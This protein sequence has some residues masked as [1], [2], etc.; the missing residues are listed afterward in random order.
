M[1]TVIEQ[2][3]NLFFKRQEQKANDFDSLAR[4]I[5]AGDDVEPDA[6]IEVLDDVG[7]SAADLDSKV[8]YYK[9]RLALKAKVD[10]LPELQSKKADVLRTAGEESERWVKLVEEHR[11]ILVPLGLEEEKLNA[12]IQ[13]A[14]AAGR[15]LRTSYVGPAI[16]E[17]EK[18]GTES[19]ALTRQIRGV[20]K[21]RDQ[22]ATSLAKNC[23]RGLP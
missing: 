9:Q 15:K 11:R 14:S 3:S 22:N 7:Q 18:L 23:P 10:S 13:D 20:E 16:A 17:L 21:V 12:A 2:V 19:A 6:V 5:A 4:S 1:S 8:G